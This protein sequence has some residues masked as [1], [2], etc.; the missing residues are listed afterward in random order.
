MKWLGFATIG[1]ILV[2]F[3]VQSRGTAVGSVPNRSPGTHYNPSGQPAPK[4]TAQK[5]QLEQAQLQLLLYQARMRNQ[6]V[7]ASG[8]SQT[9]AVAVSKK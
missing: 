2:P 4:T 8:Q 7:A 3:L 6:M 1:M 5:A 9:L